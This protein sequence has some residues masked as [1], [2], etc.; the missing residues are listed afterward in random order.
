MFPPAGAA[1]VVAADG[2]AL[3]AAVAKVRP[4]VFGHGVDS[5]DGLNQTNHPL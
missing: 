1:L 2:D 3:K 4:G 5:I